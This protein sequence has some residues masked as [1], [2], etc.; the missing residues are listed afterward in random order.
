[1]FL[2]AISTTLA[3]LVVPSIAANIGFTYP[4]CVN[5]PAAPAARATA[6]V[7]AMQNSE[8]L[9]NL[10]NQA[11]GISRLGLSSYNWWS[12]ALHGV[13]TVIG[14]EARA[15]GNNGHAALD[16]WTPNINP[17][18][19]PRWGRGHGTP[20][21]DSLRV[22]PT[23]KH[24]AG[25]DEEATRYS[26]NAQISIQD[27]AEYYFPSFQACTR[28]AKAASVMCSYNAVNGVPS[29]ANDYPLNTILRQHWGWTDNNQYIVSDC[30]AVSFIYNPHQYTTTYQD[31]VAAAFSAGTDKMCAGMRLTMAGYFD[32]P[33]S[34]YR[35]LAAMD[36]NC[37]SAKDL[38]LQIA[39]EGLVLLKNDGFLPNSFTNDTR[40]KMLRGYSGK[41]PYTNSPVYAA[42]KLGI[43][44]NYA[45]GPITQ[46]GS[47]NWTTI[48]FFAGIDNTIEKEQTD[49]TAISWPKAQLALIQ[50]LTSLGKLVVI[51][52]M[53]THIDD[54]PLLNTTNIRAILWAGYPGQD[55][56]TAVMNVLTGAFAASGRLPMTMYPSNYTNQVSI[57]DMTL[58]P[59]SSSPGYT[60]WNLSFG[61]FPSA[62]FIQDLVSKCKE[63]SLD[64]C[65]FQD[66]PITIKNIGSLSSDFVVLAFVTGNYGPIPYSI[67]TLATYQRL[68]KILAGQTQ[69]SSLSMVLG[70]LG[71]IDSTGSRILY[72][73]NYTI[74]L[75]QPTAVILNFTLMGHSS[76][77]R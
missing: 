21:E 33:A 48:I 36:L 59:Y 76:R 74:L 29:C 42:K 39:Q 7:A 17:Y 19:D 10:Y 57:T 8:K 50:K 51:V 20:G 72:P 54:S 75:D 47:D 70:V 31:A 60:N 15:F 6:L 3:A 4:D 53:G 13:G 12:E 37:A 28:D 2:F 56:G 26:F 69:N 35:N 23:C 49:R 45:T 63:V 68:F 25:Y 73:G 55:G 1:M 61:S 18:K 62:F 71:R 64:L 38:A 16:F 32:G 27:L 43:K 24:Y 65:P 9:A 67:K 66:I 5:A 58:R 46:A 14:I 11:P 44:V 52:K 22:L 41:A 40:S 77:A 30:D 34:T